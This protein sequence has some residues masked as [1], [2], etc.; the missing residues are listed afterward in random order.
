MCDSCM[1][2]IRYICAR[3]QQKINVKNTEEECKKRRVNMERTISGTK[4]RG[5][6]G[7]PFYRVAT[8]E[9]SG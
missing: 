2:L 8:P 4:K 7:V 9:S 5:S 3:E 6:S 1:S